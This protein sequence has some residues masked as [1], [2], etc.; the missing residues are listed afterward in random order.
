[1]GDLCSA[2]QAISNLLFRYARLIDAADFDGVA[3]LFEQ[4]TYAGMP[5]DQLA[6]MFRQII[7]L[8]DGK[9]GTR[10]VTTNVEIEFDDDGAAATVRS[11]FTV[12]QQVAA[13]P[14]QPIVAG[15]YLDRVVAEDGTWRFADRAIEMT[16]IGDLS[17][18]LRARR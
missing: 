7:I 17:Q 6:A 16:L 3:Q 9:M 4:A 10:H 14:L 1:V 13:L 2:E 8:H 15:H 18:H 12:F 11:Y 5:G